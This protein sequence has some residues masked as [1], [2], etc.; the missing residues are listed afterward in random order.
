MHTNR[1]QS[2]PGMLGTSS[3]SYCVWTTAFSLPDDIVIGTAFGSNVGSLVE[4]Y[5]KTGE[6]LSRDMDM[7]ENL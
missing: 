1:V 3:G 2:G 5:I 7:I 4:E 6:I